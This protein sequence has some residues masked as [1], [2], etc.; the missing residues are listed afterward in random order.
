VAAAL[1]VKTRAACLEADLTVIADRR[2]VKRRP[3]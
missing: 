2:R 1:R 3:Q